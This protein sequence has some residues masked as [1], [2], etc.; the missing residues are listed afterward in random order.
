MRLLLDTHVLLWAT[1]RPQLLPDQLQSQLL[2]PEHTLILSAATAWELSIKHHLGKLP[3]AAPLLA[4]SEVARQ[5]GAEILSI[6]AVHAVH[7]GALAWAHRDPFD[8]MLVAQAQLEGCRLVT[9]DDQIRDF[10]SVPLYD[11]K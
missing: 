11:W 1:L 8:R 5:L 10:A 4:F 2:N 6:S 9:L 3:E 7:A